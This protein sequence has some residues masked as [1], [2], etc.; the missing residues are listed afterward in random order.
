MATAVATIGDNNPPEPINSAY[1]AI[2]LDIDDLFETAQGFLDGDPIENQ[3][4]ADLVNKLID[5][6]R[7]ARGAAEA[8]RKL[9]AKPFDDGK[10]AVQA[11]WTPLT[12][13]KKG[14]CALI[15]D[16][17]KRALTPWLNKLEEEKREVARKAR[18]EADKAAAA[19]REALQ[20]S[21]D[22]EAR[23]RAEALLEE[24]KKAE[25]VATKAE[26][27][28]AHAKGGEGRA[29]GLRSR[30]HP[31]IVDPVILARHFWLTRREEVEEALLII[32]RKEVNAGARTIPGCN[33]IE[34][35]GAV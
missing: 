2:K 32:A 31:E 19:A 30:F 35:R 34:T 8:Q 21:I 28:K 13:E 27:S 22:L 16:T 14:R 17:A 25:K 10:A 7:K 23:E 1:E 24:A 26:N 20:V 9:E 5:N 12:D 3:E 4:T 6:A 11:L 33:I 29:T 15:I 18:E